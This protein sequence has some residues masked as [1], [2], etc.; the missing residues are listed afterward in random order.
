MTG[1]PLKG[2]QRYYD[3]ILP[4]NVNKL[5]ERLEKEHNVKL[6]RLEDL[7]IRSN[8]EKYNSP[9]YP[10]DSGPT[11][12]K[13]KGFALTPELK[14]IF[15]GTGISAYREGGQVKMRSGVMALPGNGVVR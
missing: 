6:P 3:K 10:A 14:E 13:V 7:E 8:V 11:L 2:H 9:N 12:G 4:K 15:K 5:M 1:G